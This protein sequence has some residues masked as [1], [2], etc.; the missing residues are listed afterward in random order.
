MSAS[1]AHV[2]SQI[3]LYQQQQSDIRETLRN[4]LAKLELRTAQLEDA[5]KMLD[6]RTEEI[7]GRCVWCGGSTVCES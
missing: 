3:T 6:H 4:G 5:R 2:N 7:G 1:D